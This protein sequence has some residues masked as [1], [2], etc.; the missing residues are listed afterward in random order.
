[1]SLEHPENPGNLR[2]V[3]I[4]L[5]LTIYSPMA[6]VMLSVAA[7]STGDRLLTFD[8]LTFLYAQCPPDRSQQLSIEISRNLPRHGPS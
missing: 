3:D 1:M 7:E 6:L 5:H 4:L 8:Q 2:L